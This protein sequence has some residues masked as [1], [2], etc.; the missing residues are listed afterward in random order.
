MAKI[1]AFEAVPGF[2]MII[3]SP[4]AAGVRLTVAGA[5][6]ERHWNPAKEAQAT[7]RMYWIGQKR[8]VHVHYPV[9]LHPDVDSFDVNLDRLLRTKVALKDAVVV[10]QQV[11]QAEM[12]RGLGLL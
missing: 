1:R 11:A 6:L 8:E 9:A 3:M 5:N 10:P 2:N 4:L 7:D 12:E